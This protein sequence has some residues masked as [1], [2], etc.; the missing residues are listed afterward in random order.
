MS[1]SAEAEVKVDT[2]DDKMVERYLLQHPDFFVQH[3]YLLTEL[4]LPHDSGSAVS[5]VERQVTVMREEIRH[6]RA[7]LQELI[8]IAANN[9][10]LIESI[11]RFSLALMKAAEP[12]AI[13][14]CLSTCLHD[15]FQVDAVS[16]Q[17][18]QG[19]SDELTTLNLPYVEL[20]GAEDD[21][22]VDYKA[23]VADGKPICGELDEALVKALFGENAEG[24]ASVAQ[25]PLMTA[26]QDKAEVMGVLYI[27]SHD[28]QRFHADQGTVFLEYLAAIIAG[29]LNPY[30]L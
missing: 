11:Q 21:R 22:A 26:G 2:I 5:L 16:L 25:L 3:P 27:A 13:I 15:D 18:F 1:T 17:L 4:V 23:L 29:K 9:D 20:I 24:V 10:G 12:E 19:W 8:Q 30:L 14:R 7:R 28:V 6:Y